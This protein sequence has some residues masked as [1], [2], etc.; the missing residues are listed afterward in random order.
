[1]GENDLQEA[2]RR[3]A[4]TIERGMAVAAGLAGNA[5]IA[6]RIDFFEIEQFI[7][8]NLYELG[9]FDSRRRTATI[10]EIVSRYN[11]IV[12]KAE[13]DPSLKIRLKK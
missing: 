8:L 5:G 1:M 7:A 12:E 11:Q 6:D 4:V 9:G 10:A 13:T 2:L 3:F